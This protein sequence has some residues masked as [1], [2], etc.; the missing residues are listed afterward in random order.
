M[1]IKTRAV[2]ALK[3]EGAAAFAEW[4]WTALVEKRRRIESELL[5]TNPQE[6]ERI[7]GKAGSA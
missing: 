7:Y 4:T 3:A 6:Y 1:T 5:K 2:V